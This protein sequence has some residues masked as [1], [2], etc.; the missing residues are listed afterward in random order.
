MERREQEAAWEERKKQA[1]GRENGLATQ[2]G[3]QF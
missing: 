3:K 1:A 2:T